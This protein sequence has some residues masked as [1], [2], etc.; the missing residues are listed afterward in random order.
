M[1][2]NRV[3]FAPSPLAKPKVDKPSCW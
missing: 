2:K 1:P 3:R